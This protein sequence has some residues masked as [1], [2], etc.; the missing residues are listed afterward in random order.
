MA[1]F[2]VS[3]EH[4]GQLRSES[5]FAALCAANPIPASSGKTHRHRLNPYCD[6]DANAALHMIAVVRMGHDPATRAYV[7]RRHTDG[8]SRCG[9]A[10]ALMVTNRDLRAGSR[11]DDWMLLDHGVF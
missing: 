8:W 4:A 9:T 10:I 3:T 2:G 11:L 7:A 5:A 6:R 1:L